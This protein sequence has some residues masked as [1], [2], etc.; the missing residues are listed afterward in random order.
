M[1]LKL[2]KLLIGFDELERYST[3]YQFSNR[4][5]ES[6]IQKSCHKPTTI[7]SQANEY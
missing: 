1:E 5:H 4:T 2:H 6:L 3:R 7:N